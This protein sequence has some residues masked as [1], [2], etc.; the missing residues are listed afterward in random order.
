MNSQPIG[1]TT[2]ERSSPHDP[3]GIDILARHSASADH[4]KKSPLLCGDLVT[5]KFMKLDEKFGIYATGGD[6]E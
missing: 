5:D 3:S 6:H 1:I 4:N 2:V